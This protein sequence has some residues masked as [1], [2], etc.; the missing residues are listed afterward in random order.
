M[1][2]N[3]EAFRKDKDFICVHNKLY[4]IEEYIE[5]IDI[6]EAQVEELKTK[7]ERLR[8]RIKELERIK[9]VPKEEKHCEYVGGN[10]S[11]DGRPGLPFCLT[12][13]PENI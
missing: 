4:T 5:R 12:V 9:V 7:N 1:S 10:Y 2:I 11:P 13:G 3:I 8:I 6:L